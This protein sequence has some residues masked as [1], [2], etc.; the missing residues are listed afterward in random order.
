MN[1]QLRELNDKDIPLMESWLQK[2]ACRLL[3]SRTR[4]LAAGDQKT[5]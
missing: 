2:E 3:V 4:G 1:A 5:K